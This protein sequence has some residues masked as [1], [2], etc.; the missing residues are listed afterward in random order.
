MIATAGLALVSLLTVGQVEFELTDGRTVAITVDG[1]LLAELTGCGPDQGECNFVLA[2]PAAGTM[3]LD[4]TGKAPGAA[5]VSPGTL[6]ITG[7]W[8]AL[9]LNQ[10]QLAHGQTNWPKTYYLRDAGLFCCAWWETS[11]SAGR[12][13]RWDGAKSDP[14]QGN[15]PF[16]PAAEVVYDG[17]HPVRER[18][19]LR[20]AKSLWDAALPAIAEPSEYRDGL[21]QM[22][23]LDLWG[24]HDA[25][26]L[27][28]LFGSLDK[29][30]GPHVKLLTVLQNW[31]AGGFDS[32]LPDS[33]WLPDYPP[34]LAVGTVDELRE[35]AALGNRLGGFAFRTNY[36]FCRDNAPSVKA[37]LTARA[38]G[39]D[40]KPKWHTQPATWPALVARQEAELARLWQPTANFTDQLT[41]GGG[42][43]AYTDWSGVGQASDTLAGALR[44]Q[45]AMAEGIKAAVPGPLGSE[46]LNQQDLIG[47][48]VDYGDFGFMGGH[49]RRPPVDYKLRRMHG[50]TMFYGCG[51]SYRF[52][53]LPPFKQY[54][55]GALR[56][57]D[58]S[59]LMDDYR[60]AEIG[61]GN[62]A[63]VCWPVP[64]D[65]LL[66]ELMVVGRAQRWY[67]LQDIDT[68]EYFH[69]GRFESLESMVKAGA[70]VEARPWKQQQG[71]FDRVAVRFV[72][73]VRIMANRGQEDWTVELPSGKLVLP[74][75]GWA[76]C[77]RDGQQMAFSAYLPG[78][79]TR[80]DK[81]DEGPGGLRFV[82]PRGAAVDGSTRLRLWNGEELLW[83]AD[84]ETGLAEQDGRTFPILMPEPEPL[85]TIDFATPTAL[86]GLRPSAGVLRVEELDGGLAYTIA[87]PDPQLHTPP[88]EIDGQAGD[89]LRI[90]MSADAGELGQLYFATAADPAVSERQVVRL[91]VVPDG[92]MRT[93]ELAVGKHAK[94]AGQRITRLRF[95]PVHGP[96]AA[97]V[98]VRE[99]KLSR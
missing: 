65:W 19:N 27:K 30:V 99:V 6:T 78:T 40:G 45:R 14:R 54:H 71:L 89:T 47:K 37:G 25:A 98:V 43:Q 93:Y 59:A 11:V 79:T 85:T 96:A 60:C 46:T 63:Y 21:A 1:A 17:R 84:P 57:W 44:N 91:K 81:L 2:T 20:I 31:Q 49:D 18:L 36:A 4:L 23:F 73:G 95:D 28:H 77:D 42:S 48:W 5:V 75:T 72:N 68:I 29:L 22:A 62:G 66:T 16:Q 53:E 34:S 12:G 92:Q 3:Q 55:A 86:R 35:V 83:S 74:R 15:G 52:F 80:V 56:L 10:Y 69:D 9:D 41:S 90:T 33:L 61:F 39:D 70:I 97:L 7:G 38:V 76:V 24:S 13:Y 58:D 88:L 67:A 51:L 50:L 64:V 32:L 94:W 87:D 26:E 82:N 8:T